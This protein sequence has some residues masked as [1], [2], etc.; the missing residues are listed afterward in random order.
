MKKND[1]YEEIGNISPD[2]IA[3]ADPLLPIATHKTRFRIAAICASVALFLALTL[4][5]LPFFNREEPFSAELPDDLLEFADSKYI[6]AI[7]SIYNNS[8]LG[9]SDY[10]SAPGNI[11]SDANGD[12]NTVSYIE[13]TDNQIKG[14]IEGDLFKRSKTHIFYVDS[15][16]KTINSYKINGENTTLAGQYKIDENTLNGKDF[17]P[18]EIYLSKDCD[19]LTVVGQFYDYDDSYGGLS[20]NKKL[21]LASFDVSNPNKIKLKKTVVLAGWYITSRSVDGRI[22][23][24]YEYGIYTYNKKINFADEGQFIPQIDVGKG[25]ESIDVRDIVFTES[26]SD[27]VYTVILCVD[28]DSLRIEDVK[29]IYKP[30]N[31]VFVSEDKIVLVDNYQ[32]FYEYEENSAAHVGRNRFSDVSIFSIEKGN[33]EYR[34]GFTLEGSVEGQYSI[35][36]YNGILRIAATTDLFVWSGDVWIDPK[37]G[38]IDFGESSEL[39]SPGTNASLY[40]IDTNTWQK[41]AEVRDFAPW[42]EEVTSARFDGNMAYICTAE[43]IILSDPVYFF[44]L[45]D[46]NNITYTDTG[47]I[48][49]YSTSLVDFTEGM[50]LGIGYGDSRNTLKIEVYKEVEGGVESVCSY[51]KE[52]VGFSEDY[53][54]YY[55][56]RE[57]G[58]VG[59]MFRQSNNCTYILLHF[60]GNRI[61]EV[62]SEEM[63]KMSYPAAA[64]ATLIDD[65]FY[66]FIFEKYKA[67]KLP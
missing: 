18:R 3:E 31:E 10:S 12:R 35:D 22:Y 60:D 13:V 61:S 43:R 26:S 41:V 6:K 65:C 67:V 42:G 47:T 33:M 4:V 49:G 8:I 28:E 53:K 17:T 57:R 56:D 5:A 59:L 19:T 44:D 34:G 50:L 21:V 36:E 45:T 38:W 14:V 51:I 27:S 52:D 63:G 32:K 30:V 37:T 62:I 15:I 29:A 64:R 54:A 66:I 20:Y 25:F 55:I 40:C 7:Y 39:I 24:I 48:E 58:L 2:L 16:N 23:L 11:M 9:Y 1:I 46:L